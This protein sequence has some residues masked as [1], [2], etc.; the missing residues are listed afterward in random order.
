MNA[1][2]F[3]ADPDLEDG[4]GSLTGRS[5]PHRGL[6]FPHDP[7]T[8]VCAYEHGIVRLI[9]FSAYIGW[10]V[11][12][13]LDDGTY[14]GWAH[15]RNIA[16]HVGQ[17]VSADT[18]LG[19]VAGARDNPGSTW[20]GAHSHTTYGNSAQSIFEGTVWDPWPR[21]SKALTSPSTGKKRT[22]YLVWDTTGTGYLVTG[23]GR[24]A[25]STMQ[26]YNLFRRLINSNQAS[27]RPET[28]NAEEMRLMDVHLKLLAVQKQ[29]DVTVD[30][31]KLASAI[32][33]A[34]GKT[35]NPK[36]DIAT[37]KLVAAFDVATPRVVAAMLAEQSKRLAKT[38]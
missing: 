14:A 16:V 5:S 3:Y 22:M 35:W 30:V 7:G 15:L 4:F 18:P 31:A 9:Q 21:I 27:D 34:L 24:L 20:R 17:E 1:Q 37:E 36:V 38:S 8:T 32:G 33:D 19:E 10:C 12:V 29:S 25:I 11:S 6:D 2:S 28:F 26:I 13:Q 23:D